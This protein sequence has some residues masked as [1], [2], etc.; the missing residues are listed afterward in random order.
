MSEVYSCNEI[1]SWG[2][3]ILGSAYL[4]PSCCGLNRGISS[5]F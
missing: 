2:A 5:K 3:E 1:L 4:L